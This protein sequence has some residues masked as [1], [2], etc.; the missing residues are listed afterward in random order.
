VWTP[1]GARLSQSGALLPVL[2]F[3]FG[4]GFQYGDTAQPI[5]D[6]VNLTRHN[7]VIVVTMNYR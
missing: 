4:G 1:S 6:G 7:D 2:A 3:V 5:Y